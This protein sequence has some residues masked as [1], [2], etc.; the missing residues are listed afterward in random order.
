LLLKLTVMNAS[1]LVVV[2]KKQHAGGGCRIIFS[3]VNLQV[4]IGSFFF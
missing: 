1:S 3:C 2:F 4:I